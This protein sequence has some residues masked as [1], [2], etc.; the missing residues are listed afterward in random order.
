MI[1]FTEKKKKRRGSNISA[2]VWNNSGGIW[3]VDLVDSFYS[4]R[5]DL[6]MALI[7]CGGFYND[8]DGHGVSFGPNS[9]VCHFIN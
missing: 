5:G 2:E 9:G 6:T 1:G 7:L 8:F 3:T 4:I